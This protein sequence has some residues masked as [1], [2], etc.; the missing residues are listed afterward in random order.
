MFV[1]TAAEALYNSGTMDCNTLGLQLAAQ[2]AQWVASSAHKL[3]YLDQE[4]GE[5]RHPLGL[6]ASSPVSPFF[7]GIASRREQR[8]C[9]R[10][11]SECKTSLLN[12]TSRSVIIAVGQLRD[13]EDTCQK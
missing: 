1:D 11:V 8:L 2:Q 6:V 9:G 13:D 10:K 3:G 5:K 7:S 4:W 12:C